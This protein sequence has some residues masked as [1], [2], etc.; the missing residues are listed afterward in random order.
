MSVA[1]RGLDNTYDFYT[2][3][4]GKPFE[5]DA[6]GMGCCLI[7]RSVFER[8]RSPWFQFSQNSDGT[9]FGE[10][11]HFFEQAGRLGIKALAIPQVQCSHFRVVDLLDVVRAVAR[12]Q[13]PRREPVAAC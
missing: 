1:R 7:E 9:L 11:L 2:R 3:C 5:V 4:D 12:A 6:A 8:I 13:A 10:D